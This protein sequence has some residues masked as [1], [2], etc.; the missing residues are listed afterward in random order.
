MSHACH[1]PGCKMPVPPKLWGC[2]KH[3]RMLPT[4]LRDKIWAHYKPGQEIT[5]IPSKEYIAVAKEVQVWIASRE[6]KHVR[7]RR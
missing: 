5:K 7:S 6:A 1:W 3:W 2:L 4:R